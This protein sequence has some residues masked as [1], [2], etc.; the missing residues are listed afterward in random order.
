[1]ACVRQSLCCPCNNVTPEHSNPVFGVWGFLPGAQNATNKKLPKT[2][3]QADK[4]KWS[5]RWSLSEQNPRI[6][7]TF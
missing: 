5:I 2:D 6:L 3:K 4:F 1:M 7:K